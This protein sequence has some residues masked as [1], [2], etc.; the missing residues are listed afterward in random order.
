MQLLKEKEFSAYFESAIQRLIDEEVFR[1][2]A[3]STQGAF[4]AEIDFV[5]DYE[6]ASARIPESLTNMDAQI[7]G[8]NHGLQS[9][10]RSRL[11]ITL[12]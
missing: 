8:K 9:E 6:N 1:I 11:A 10:K 2:E 3:V 4:W 5:E 7:K 12:L